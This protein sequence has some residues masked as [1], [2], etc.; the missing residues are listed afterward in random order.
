MFHCVLTLVIKKM[1][2]NLEEYYISFLEVTH[3]RLN[4]SVVNLQRIISNQWI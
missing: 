3:C 2:A 4:F 1:D